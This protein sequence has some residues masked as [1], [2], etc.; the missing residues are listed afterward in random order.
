MERRGILLEIEG[1]EASLK[2]QL[3]RLKGPYN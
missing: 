1:V 2:E 3:K